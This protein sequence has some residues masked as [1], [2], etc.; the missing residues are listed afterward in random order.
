[1]RQA[2]TIPEQRSEAEHKLESLRRK[3]GS[4]VLDGKVI[5]HSRVIEAEGNIDALF[6]AEAVADKRAREDAEE[7][8]EARLTELKG[9]IAKKAE[10]YFLT[11]QEAERETRALVASLKETIVF[12]REISD[13]CKE[14]GTKPPQGISGPPLERRLGDRLSA[15]LRTVTGHPT[16]LGSIKLMTTWRKP[17]DSWIDQ[18]LNDL[19]GDLAAITKEN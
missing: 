18:E 19:G 12:G 9:R 16:R 2:V 5:D 8:V 7:A 4:D 14:I 11:I 17:E 13:L 6:D 15:L 10:G 1:M 3:R